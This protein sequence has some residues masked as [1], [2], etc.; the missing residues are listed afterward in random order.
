[1]LRRFTMQ[2]M[3]GVETE[4]LILSLWSLAGSYAPAKKKKSVP[5][6]LRITRRTSADALDHRAAATDDGMHRQCDLSDGTFT[7]NHCVVAY[8]RD[9]QSTCVSSKPALISYET[10]ETSLAHFFRLSSVESRVGFICPSLH[11]TQ[12]KTLGVSVG[13][14]ALPRY[15][16]QWNIIH[17]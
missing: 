8:Q 7:R 17:C 10:S 16:C 14:P 3:N 5:S 13:Q 12:S 4:T 1:M 9:H 6:P 11:I 15:P 2:W